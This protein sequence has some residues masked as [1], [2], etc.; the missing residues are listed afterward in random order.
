MS[1][2]STR[3]RL[4]VMVTPALLFYVPFFVLPV[5]LS[6]YYSLTSFSGS[7]GSKFV[8]LSNYTSLFH[9]TF[10]WISFR[11]TG[12]ILAEA[13]A[14]LVPAA[15]SLAL[16]MRD[17]HV[18]GA[19]AV[20][21]LIFAPVIIAPIL[22]GLIFVFILD[23]NIGLIN[24]ALGALGIRGKPEW[25]GGT[26]LTPYAIGFVYIWQ[27]MGFILT[28]FYAGLQMLPREVFE[29][30]TVDGARYRDQVRYIT[31]PLLRDTFGICTVLIITGVFR[32]FELVYELT[33]GGPVHDSDVLASYMYYL[34]FTT[35]RYG[36]GMAL[37]VV[38]CVLSI[39]AF[40][41]YLFAAAR[42]RDK[43]RV[44]GDE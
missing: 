41:L 29:A 7:G 18:P 32:I 10:F 16:L 33:G 24:Q 11:N 40:S 36:Y 38:I 19:Q 28:I 35:F 42:R 6:A 43:V 15:F 3:W 21:A 20:R 5:A 39:G 4:C 14:L 2:L 22:V 26:T 1:L 13:L 37:A 9:D 8:G 27:T 30:A 25:I 17:R 31:I 23:P 12:I 34:T 44:F